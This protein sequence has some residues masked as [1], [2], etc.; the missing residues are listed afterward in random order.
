M[1]FKFLF[2]IAIFFSIINMNAQNTGA[3]KGTV[4]TEQGEP[5]MGASIFV[6]GLSMGT[7][8]DS[9]GAFLLEKMPS[10]TY[11]IQVSYIGYNTITKQ[12]VITKSEIIQ[13]FTLKESSYMLEGVVVTSQKRE[14]KNKDVPIAITSYG[15]DFLENQGTF[16]YDALSEYVPGFQVQIQSV[17]N[18]G[19]VVRGITSDSGDSRVEPR[20]SIFQDGVSISKSRG[21]V[22]EL[23]DIERVEVLKGPQGTLFGRGAQIGA[24]HIIQNKAKNETSGSVKLGYGNF[25]Q[26]LATGHYN[27]PLVEDKLFFRAAAIYNKRDGFIENLSGGDLNGKETVAFRTSFKYLL[28]DDTTLDVIANWQKDTPPGTSFKSGT[29]APLGGDTNPNTFADL[30]RGEELGLD[31]TVWGVTAILKHDFNDIWDVTSTTAYREFDSNEAFDADGT[32]APALFFNEISIGKQ[33]SQEF[34]FNF[35]TDDKFRGFFGANFFYEDGSQSV[36]WEYN[37][38]S[39][40]MLL[41]NPANLVVGGVPILLPAIPNDP[42]T[43]GA[44]AGAPLNSFNKETYTNFGENYS[45]DIFA[46]A[47]YD[48]TDKLSFTL[49]LRATLENI[50]AAYEVIDTEIPSVLGYLSGNY[51][52]TLFAPT[53]GKIEASDNFLSAVGRFAINYEINE[54]ITLFGTTSRGRRPNVINVTAIETTILSDE[55]VWSYEVGAKSLFLNNSLQ[56]DVNAYMYDY[57]NFQTSVAK[58]EN[59]VLTNTTED[60]GNAS[61][62]GFEVALQYAFLKTSSFFANYGYIDASFDDVDSNGNEQALAGNTFR[63]TPKNSFSAGFN[64]NIDAN[65]NLRYFFRPTYTYKSKVFFEETNLPEISQDGY[66]ILNIKTGLVFNKDYELTFFMNNA[67][68]K[69]FIVDAGNTG[70]AFGIPT[71]IAGA[72]RFFGVQVKANF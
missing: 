6:K 33:F 69:E 10:N 29:Y 22:V 32:V 5:I 3:L 61:S 53:N 71:F 49:G 27:A 11:V 18:P 46:D 57:S 51:P 7:T 47:S 37:E 56:F 8:S 23:Y 63:L 30:E 19:I 21:S 50:N 58:L 38:R 26:F 67:L 20:V 4:T 65:D 16:E 59:G 70:G 34:R 44:I 66:G 41:L 42:N 35:D 48:L 25:N 72:P 2:T 14:Q 15:T 24:M 31:R 12:V 28:N 45:G 1:H 52:N 55:T 13:N 36:P 54:E 17:N 9:N 60:S 39:V 64:V 40:A 62:F 43:F 68:D